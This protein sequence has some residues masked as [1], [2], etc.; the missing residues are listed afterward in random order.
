MTLVTFQ[1]FLG[2]KWISGTVG[3]FSQRLFFF[4]TTRGV[5]VR[6]LK[7]IQSAVPSRYLNL[8]IWIKRTSENQATGS[9]LIHFSSVKAMRES[10]TYDWLPTAQCSAYRALPLYLTPLPS[11]LIPI[12][13]IH[14]QDTFSWILQK[15][16]CSF[17][18]SSIKQQSAIICLLADRQPMLVQELLCWAVFNCSNN[19]FIMRFHQTPLAPAS[20]HRKWNAYLLLST[21]WLLLLKSHPCSPQKLFMSISKVSIA[22]CI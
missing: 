17:H 4:L 12:C 11:I 3:K 13:G 6:F 2:T 14:K 1:W 21:F 16:Y 22:F 5:T 18:G 7:C 15:T 10:L 8:V 9:L 19:C 20:R